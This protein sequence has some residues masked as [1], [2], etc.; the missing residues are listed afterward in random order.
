[1]NSKGAIMNFRPSNNMLAGWLFMLAVVGALFFV[2][3]ADAGYTVSV[4]PGEQNGVPEETLSFTITI[5]N[6][7]PDDDDVFA[8]AVSFVGNVEDGCDGC[9]DTWISQGSLSI[10]AEEQASTNFYVKI[11]DIAHAEA[12]SDERVLVEVV[13]AVDTQ[14]WSQD[15]RIIV[16]AAYGCSLELLTLESPNLDPFD[17]FQFDFNITNSE[18]NAE[19]N[20][21]L[22][23]S[24][25]SEDGMS[26]AYPPQVSD[27]GMGETAGFSVT[28][29]IDE[30]TA[31]KGTRYISIT[32]T[33]ADGSTNVSTTFQFT[34]NIYRD[35]QLSEV[36]TGSKDIIEGGSVSYGLIVTNVGNAA[37]TFILGIDS[38]TVPADWDAQLGS[39]TDTGILQPGENYTFS[40]ALF[41]YAPDDA[42]A[43]DIALIDIVVTSDADSNTSASF[44][45]R[46]TVA[47]NYK[48]T[49]QTSSQTSGGSPGDIVSYTFTVTNAGNGNDEFTIS[50]AEP[51]ADQCSTNNAACWGVD[52][53]P[54]D[55]T[56][57]MAPDGTFEFTLNITIN[58][59]ALKQ[60]Y[61]VV[62]TATSSTAGSDGTFTTKNVYVE[63][64]ARA[65][66]NLDS[67]GSSNVEVDAGQIAEYNLTVSNNGNDEDDVSLSAICEVCSD[68][69]WT[70]Q[71]VGG[72]TVTI[73][74][75]SSVT[76]VFRVDS[77]DDAIANPYTTVITA[78]SSID[79]SENSTAEVITEIKEKFEVDLDSTELQMPGVPDDSVVFSLT[80]SNDG[81]G[82]DE[83]EM[84]YQFAESDSAAIL[85][86]PSFSN[87]T[88]T[89]SPGESASITFTVQVSSDADDISHSILIT[90]T[91]KNAQSEAGLTVNDTVDLTVVVQPVYD[92]RLTSDTTVVTADPGESVS[93]EMTLQNQGTDE[94]TITITAD[95]TDAIYSVS[96]SPNSPTVGEDLNVTISVTIIVDE[97][98][99]KDIYNITF[100]AISENDQSI[101][102]THV[103]D[104][105]VAQR[106]EVEILFPDGSFEAAPSEEVSSNVVL[107]NQGTGDDRVQLSIDNDGCV[108]RYSEANCVG[109]WGSLSQTLVPGQNGTFVP[110]E[111]AEVLLTVTVPSSAEPSVTAGVYYVT[112]AVQSLDNETATDY[113]DIQI[114]VKTISVDLAGVTTEAD[115]EPGRTGQFTVDVTN[116]GQV[117]DT[118][119]VTISES[120]GFGWASFDQDGSTEIQL[121]LAAGAISTVTINLELPSYA[122]V[123]GSE[124][125]KL[126]ADFSYTFKVEAKTSVGSVEAANSETM[127]ATIEQIYGVT[128][129]LIN[130]DITNATTYPSAKLET[131][132]FDV[133]ITNLGNGQDNFKVETSLPTG[134]SVGVFNAKSSTGCTDE[135]SQAADSITAAGDARVY[136]CLTPE[137]NDLDVGSYPI[138]MSVKARN[139]QDSPVSVDVE[140]VIDEPVRAFTLTVDTP[141]KEVAPEF[142]SSGV[143]SST[144]NVVK[145]RIVVQNDGSHED[146][147]VPEM[148]D[149]SSES[150]G[151]IGGNG[152][153]D[154]GWSWEFAESQTGSPTWGG[155][156]TYELIDSGAQKELWFIM[157]VEDEDVQSGN[158]TMTLK[159]EVIDQDGNMME[160]KTTAV[161][162]IVKEPTPGMTLSIYENVK[163]IQ[164]EYEGT[165][166]SNMVQFKIKIENTGSHTDY[167]LPV[168]DPDAVEDNWDIVFETSSGSDWDDNSGESIQSGDSK[169]MY[170][171]ITVDDEAEIGNYTIRID[172]Q[173]KEGDSDAS[174][175]AVL[176]VMVLR[177]DLSLTPSDVTLLVNNA[178]AN[179]STVR[180]DDSLA[181]SVDVKNSAIDDEFATKAKNALVEVYIYPRKSPDPGSVM[182]TELEF[183]HGFSQDADYGFI[184]MIYQAENR[185]DVGGRVISTSDWSVIGGE[186]YIEVRVDYD[187][188]DVNGKILETNEN[189]NKAR[190]AELLQIKADLSISEVYVDSKY[191][192][193]GSSVPNLGDTVTFTATIIN[194]GAAD[195]QDAK[196]FITGDTT[197]SNEILKTTSSQSYVEFDVD[198]GSTKQVTFRWKAGSV[199]SST[200]RV[201]E[202]WTGIRIT[203]NPRCSDFNIFGCDTDL[204]REFDELNRYQNNEYPASGQFTQNGHELTFN[205]LP[206][207]TIDKV[208]LNPSSPTV[209][210]TVAVTITIKNIG[211]TD[212]EYG[213]GSLYLVFDDS[214]GDEITTQIGSSI[215]RN[216]D[217]DVEF[218]WIFPEAENKNE[219]KLTFELDVGSGTSKI[220]QLSSDNDEDEVT[221]EV[222]LPALLGDVPGVDFLVKREL[223]P[224][225]PM[226]IPVILFLG[227]F[228]VGL[229]VYFKIRSLSAAAAKAGPKSESKE[230]A[231]AAA[232]EAAPAAPSKIGVSIKSPDGKTANVKVPSIMPVQRL[233]QNCV[234]NKFIPDANFDVLLDGKPVDPNATLESAGFKDGS[235]VAL[236]PTKPAPT[237]PAPT[238]PKQ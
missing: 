107:T 211:N 28:I 2:G 77:P 133:R 102:A 64:A 160:S 9:W 216:G 205:M 203:I 101:S 217:Y 175:T 145:F 86:F 98:A 80:V 11:G 118:I 222:V 33:S 213:S 157:M 238:K 225:V 204:D 143:P 230:G 191:V 62:I 74:A 39:L 38:G 68:G 208:K 114:V 220:E 30:T 70:F 219:I 119:T 116:D 155:S 201:S 34:V 29:S 112:V 113:V 232:S 36:D 22:S 8:I 31:A 84:S 234:N 37:D 212:W 233:V 129:E 168:D 190:Y 27:I 183:V 96:I 228:V 164:P 165:T 51:D 125:Q 52:L 110:E 66:I 227:V 123:T 152:C 151:D 94:D 18:G 17:T 137:E 24:A 67:A 185:I 58:E 76:V 117:S 93:F 181:I 79:T 122:N 197:T 235:E 19:D 47:Q 5:D 65:D 40:E 158:Y 82:V 43:D 179:A 186:W 97:D 138:E 54:D 153:N 161:M 210:E 53:T 141:T 26:I 237:K 121:T 32:A 104:V 111:T 182:A 176:Y 171:V 139:G 85:E 154:C 132:I 6:T 126:A 196:L 134:L 99:L 1:M 188:N 226:Y 115:I 224:G 195:I 92:V 105:D 95:Y 87:N 41:V 127:T 173:N 106:Y 55:A 42:V 198:A 150:T 159:V 215:D 120:S 218:D 209:G 60:S 142:S 202:S 23:Y 16:D 12:D 124:K 90:A 223:I 231:T 140:L 163:D 44:Q 135:W 91:S 236:A 147:F 57:Q 103:L 25:S 169:D 128:A 45:T 78:T 75:E 14:S 131:T 200:K 48:P 170:V 49:I 193:N 136:L 4:T 88:V 174:D 59:N 221:L 20:I 177:P 63:V 187:D 178:E 46:S 146:R 100:T 148:I 184:K 207:F 3:S 194:D 56:P 89:L 162:V 156:Q 172:I 130:E 189:N 214:I 206:D 81:S 192:G 61:T 167:F 69:D 71:F 72:S 7:D 73:A 166:S 35:I 199:A 83:I 13:P 149:G 144:K 15:V 109:D 50:I 180:E 10:D 229:P 108:I 21:A